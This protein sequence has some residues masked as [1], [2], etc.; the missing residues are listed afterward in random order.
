MI[1]TP[2]QAGTEGL[3]FLQRTAPCLRCGVH[4]ICAGRTEISAA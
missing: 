2:D 1:E 3:G 4:P